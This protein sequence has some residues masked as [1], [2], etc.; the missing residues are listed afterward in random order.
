[1]LERGLGVLA[2][3]DGFL[4]VLVGQLLKREFAATHDLHRP[5]QGLWAAW[6]QPFHLLRRLQIS[7][8]M[9][10][11]LEADIVDRGVVPD[12]GDDVLKLP[13][14]R[15]MKQHVVGDD[16]SDLEPRRHVGN[17]MQAQLVVRSPTQTERHVCA[18]TKQLSHFSKLDRA[19]IIR[20]I[21][22]QNADHALGVSDDIVPVQ[23]AVVLAATRFAQRDEAR[24]T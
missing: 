18:I 14:A 2:R 7:V 9:S 10:L 3:Y 17:L 21:R 13:T 15:L 16:G 4:R 11:A 6:K 5:R 23:D 8:R 24:Q 22:H 1:M 19:K 12:T 20:Q